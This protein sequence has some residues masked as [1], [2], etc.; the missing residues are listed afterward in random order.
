MRAKLIP[1]P[2]RTAD[3]LMINNFLAS[4]LFKVEKNEFEPN[5]HLFKYSLEEDFSSW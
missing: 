3:S 2:L 5:D 4:F 1:H